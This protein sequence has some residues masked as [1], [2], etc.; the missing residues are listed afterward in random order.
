MAHHI[1]RLIEPGV[2][3]DYTAAARMLGVSQPRISHLMGLLL[4]APVIQDAILMG[5]IA[6]KD[7]E[8]RELARVAEWRAQ[9][10]SIANRK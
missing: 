3:A 2:I 1:D 10:I 9:E 4:L 5:R 8:L 6:P 7:K